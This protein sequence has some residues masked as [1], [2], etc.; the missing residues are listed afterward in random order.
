M[1]MFN[2]ST[3][4]LPKS[5]IEAMRSVVPLKVSDPKLCRRVTAADFRSGSSIFRR[6]LHVVLYYNK[7]SDEDTGWS[8]AGWMQESLGRALEEQPWVAGRLRRRGEERGGGGEG[9]LEIVSNDS[10]VRL[11]E[12]RIRKSLAEFIELKE[13]EED[14]EAELVF[15]KDIDGQNPQ[16]SPLFYVQEELRH[17]CG[18]GSRSRERW[19]EGDSGVNV[20]VVRV[21]R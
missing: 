12:A 16:F 5:Q 19:C 15:W 21:G 14:A 17:M 4:S 9:G 2:G 20:V 18:G 3:H 1:A 10:G 13:R 7:A 8:L 11:L 6:R